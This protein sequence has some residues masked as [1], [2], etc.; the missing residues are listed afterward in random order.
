MTAG[1][2]RERV[3]RTCSVSSAGVDPYGPDVNGNDPGGYVSG[4][5]PALASDGSHWSVAT[6]EPDTA[7]TTVGAT[8]GATPPIP[9]TRSRRRATVIDLSGASTTRTPFG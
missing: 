7:G 9:E 1:R 3:P 8:A 2:R 4:S 5:V 6:G